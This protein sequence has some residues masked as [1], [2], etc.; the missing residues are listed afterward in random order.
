M[1]KIVQL[2][3]DSSK[4]E[5]V[6]PKTL[7][8]EVY[9]GD[10]KTTIT[11]SLEE[12]VKQNKLFGQIT[13]N[14]QYGWKP[15]NITICMQGD[16]LTFGNGASIG[17][18]L[19]SRVKNYL[20]N[21]ARPNQTVTM[22]NRGIGGD[23][24]KESNEH[25]QT[26]SGADIT[27]I[28]LGTN[29]Y[30]SVASIEEFSSNYEQII[31]RELD[32]GTAVMLITPPQWGSKDWMVKESNGGLNDYVGVIKGFGN[33]YN[34]PV[35]DLYEETR[36]L[37]TIAF[38]TG[39]AIPHVHFSDIGYQFLSMKVCAFIGF[40]HPSTIRKLKNGDFLGVRPGVDGIKVPTTY[41]CIDEKSYYPT[42][43]ETTSGLGTGIKTGSEEL[44]FYYS[45]YSDED[46]LCFAPSFN[47][48][49]TDGTELLDI[50][51]NNNNLPLLFTN[52]YLHRD[53]IDRNVVSPRMNLTYANFTQ[54][55]INSNL[56]QNIYA[57]EGKPCQYRTLPTRG[58]YT[59]KVIMR[60][61]EFHGIDFLSKSVVNQ[62]TSQY[63]S[64][65][66]PLA[67]QN[68]ATEVDL[69]MPSS[70][71]IEIINGMKTVHLR[72]NVK[73]NAGN[74]FATLPPNA[75]RGKLVRLNAHDNTTPSCLVIGTTGNLVSAPNSVNNFQCE[76]SYVI[77]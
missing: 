18:D 54:G 20:N 42:G 45:I 51:I 65:W 67:L 72:I 52:P 33:K 4:T 10:G 77:Y 11:A 16:S 46:N 49:T 60:N 27:T 71:R 22:I 74:V 76:A 14:M 26:P 35:L 75:I 24:T 43:A 17:G 55:K 5:K 57:M 21:I 6:Y 64:G 28:M 56:T 47:F 66:L 12:N 30:D 32:N 69:T 50:H 1:S 68:G 34:C 3:N 2:Y 23:T 25:W 19:P 37:D 73:G 70:Y 29:D 38:K 61:C 7:A 58:W 44:T 40:Q 62:I 39:E 36:N 9:M 48:T 41:R 15:K 59:L 63:N 53:T 31:K 13:K 8:S